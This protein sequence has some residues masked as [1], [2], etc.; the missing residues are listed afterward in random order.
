MG[1]RCRIHI[2]LELPVVP[3]QQVFVCRL[4]D[5]SD[6]GPTL[7]RIHN[8]TKLSDYASDPQAMDIVLPSLYI[9][10]IVEVAF[11]ASQFACKR[12]VCMIVEHIFVG[13]IAEGLVKATYHVLRRWL[14]E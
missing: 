10:L 11:F 7:R 1:R 2:V 4:G 6:L 3:T 8:T 9:Q 13:V 14:E 5:T 12:A